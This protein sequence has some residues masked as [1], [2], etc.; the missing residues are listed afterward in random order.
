MNSEIRWLSSAPPSLRMEPSGPGTPFSRRA[1]AR[2]FPSRRTSAS[3][4]RRASRSRPTGSR[5]SAPAQTSRACA[6]GP[7]PR[8]ATVPPIDTRSFMRVAVATFQPSP[9]GPTRKESGVRASVNQTSLK[10]AP[11]DIC[12][13]GRTST[14][15]PCMS[16]TKAV[17]PLCLG[18]SGLVRASSR[19]HLEMCADD[20]QTFWPLTTHSS[21]SRSARVDSPA[22][23]EPAPGSLKSW[24]QISSA[25]KI[26][27]RKRCFCSS[28]PHATMVGPHIP[29]PIGLRIHWPRRPAAS[30]VES[31]TSWSRGSASRPP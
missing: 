31:T 21:P 28:V 19:P 15:G 16:T 11:P 5:R 30:R 3:I 22:T 24:H 29:M 13:R 2:M 14:P 4:H 18:A 7:L 9:T 23:S 26:G 12:R 10:L 27:R 1:W 20:V 17:R 25:V 6:I 8:G